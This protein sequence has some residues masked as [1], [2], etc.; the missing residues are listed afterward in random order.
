MNVMKKIL[1]IVVPAYNVEKYIRQNLDSLTGL[2]NRDALEVLVIDDGSKDSTGAIA[3]EY[4]EKYP[5][6]IRVIHQNNRG[7]GGTINTGIQEAAGKY[8]KVVDGDD[9]VD[10]LELDKYLKK[11]E[12]LD[13][14]LV[15]TDYTEYYENT[16]KTKKF[17]LPLVA[18][19]TL[20]PQNMKIDSFILMHYYTIKTE[21]LRE[22]PVRIDENCYYVDMEYIIYP[23]PF[24]K[25]IRYEKLNLYCYRLG[26]RGQSVSAEGFRKHYKENEKMVRAV[27]SYY[28][29]MTQEKS[30]KNDNY[31]LQYY[32]PLRIFD[33]LWRH[34]L[35]CMWFL[36]G[37]EKSLSR[38]LREVDNEVKEESK[39]LYNFFEMSVGRKYSLS[40]FQ[41]KLLRLTGFRLWTFV[42]LKKKLA[43]K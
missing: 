8:F 38:Y 34:E 26:R 4:F 1:T 43:R 30:F 17:E 42:R 41:I 13:E 12:I 28:R 24:V 39:E 40:N 27:F 15:F 36:K 22:M 20:F 21:V 37:E 3:D 2:E 5:Q 18:E 32:M 31:L 19:T 29:K 35:K 6:C 9:W 11:L 7:H 14:D 16:G 25:S 23:L 10:T 33:L